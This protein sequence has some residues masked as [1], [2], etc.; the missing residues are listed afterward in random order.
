MQCNF[1]ATRK[2]E[3]RAFRP[4]GLIL[5]SGAVFS[6]CVVRTR[7][8]RSQQDMSLSLLC[9]DACSVEQLFGLRKPWRHT[10]FGLMAGSA[11]SASTC[12]QIPAWCLR[13]YPRGLYACLQHFKYSVQCL[14]SLIQAIPPLQEEEI[15]SIW[16]AE[17]RKSTNRRLY[18][19]MPPVQ[20]AGPRLPLLYERDPEE[21]AQRFAG[22]GEEE[23]ARVTHEV[24]LHHISQAHSTS[25]S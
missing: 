20:L 15:A 25:E 22:A 14:T 16:A 2:K 7:V 1:P 6:G 11:W 17:R 24:S 23:A 5:Q 8:L 3:V 19:K 12:A 9:I 13:R 18:F 4:A 10:P 21:E